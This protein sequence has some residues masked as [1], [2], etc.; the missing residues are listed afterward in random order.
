MKEKSLWSKP[1]ITCQL[2]Y[3]T[4][5]ASYILKALPFI[6]YVSYIKASHLWL[7]KQNF[8][9]FMLDLSSFFKTSRQFRALGLHE[10]LY[11]KMSTKWDESKSGIYSP[12]SCFI[13]WLKC[14][15]Y[16]FTFYFL[17]LESTVHLQLFF[18]KNIIKF[19]KGS[20]P[21]CFSPPKIIYFNIF[22]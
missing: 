10:L 16:G 21:F 5:K 2:K 22:F 19:R 9:I 13:G 14:T 18:S 11:A 1:K 12:Y 7:T 20:N 8:H 17:P 3:E 15:I 6:L 4:M